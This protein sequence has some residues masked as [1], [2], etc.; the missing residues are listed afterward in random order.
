[1]KKV[2][3]LCCLL[4]SLVLAF[5]AC[6]SYYSSYKAVLL[7]RS[8]QEDSTSVSFASLDGRLVQKIKC[9]EGQT[10]LTW[11]ATLEEGSMTVSCDNG[12]GKNELFTLKGGEPAAFFIN[13][14]RGTIYL[15]LETDG[16]C[17]EGSLRFA[18][19]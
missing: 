8:Q 12:D 6:A 2:V 16:V 7:V 15:I 3:V 18:L 19:Q 4:L 11:S 17:K 5:S 13:V 1:M 10:L 9:K 14:E